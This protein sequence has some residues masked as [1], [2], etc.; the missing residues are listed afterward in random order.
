MTK[1]CF[2][3]SLINVEKYVQLLKTIYIQI[4]IN[5]NKYIISYNHIHNNVEF[6][7]IIDVFLII[8][9]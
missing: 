3:Y 2:E 7:T 8:I 9:S 5:L 4:Y 1:S 6:Y